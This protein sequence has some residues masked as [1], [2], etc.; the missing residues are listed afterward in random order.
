[1][2]KEDEFAILTLQKLFERKEKQQAISSNR[3][4]ASYHKKGGE[5]FKNI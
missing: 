2:N 1:M 3:Q 5:C 4:P